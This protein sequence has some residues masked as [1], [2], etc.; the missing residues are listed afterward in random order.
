[1]FVKTRK[2]KEVVL[3]IHI[4]GILFGHNKKKNAAICDMEGREDIMLSEID[5]E[6]QSLLR[7]T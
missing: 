3:Y 5:S 1:M 6:K 2:D 7:A 4:H